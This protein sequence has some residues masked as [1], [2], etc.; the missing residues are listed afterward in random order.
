MEVIN[1]FES[2]N[3]EFWL[4]QIKES[5]WTAGALL[6]TFVK[7]NRFY[8]ER[9]EGA[10]ILLLINEKELVSYCIYAPKDEIINTTLTP[11]MG[12]VYTYPKYRGHHYM[13]YL[14][15]EV[16]RLAKID[17]Y[18]KVY[19]STGHDGLYEKYG[20]TYKETINDVDGKICRVYIYNVI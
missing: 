15:E 18:D 20:C 10:K 2:N 6:Y 7:E 8:K 3:Q 4:N 13:K 14:F 9:G 11:W 17:G 5:D 12:F 19:I 1:L 16:N